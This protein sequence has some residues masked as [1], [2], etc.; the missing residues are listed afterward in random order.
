MNDLVTLEA[1]EATKHYGSGH[2]RKVAVNSV[3]FSVDS[4]SQVGIVGESGSG[5]STLARMLTGLAKPN[6][7]SILFN[8][9]ELTKVLGDQMQRMAFRRTVQFIAQDTSSSFDPRRKLIDSIQGPAEKLAGLKGSDR[10]ARV[11]EALA[12]VHLTSA[13]ADR[14]PPQ[15]SGG[16]RQRMSIARAL[17]VRPRLILCDEIVSAL[18]V[19][20]QGSI[21]NMLKEYVE[22]HSAGLVFVS[23][24]LPATA[25][26]TN[27]LCV[28]YDGAIVE[29][30]ETSTVLADPRDPY[31]QTLVAAYA[32]GHSVAA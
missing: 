16:Q 29:S 3:S 7:G 31:T 2:N 25:F 23:H 10:D 18:D 15:V 26:I 11:D 14:Y 12:A 19:S 21:L 20:I 27:T 32:R 1:R 30:G 13:M 22:R 24:G 6:A 4:S 28:M 8:G 9:A 17:V 5:K